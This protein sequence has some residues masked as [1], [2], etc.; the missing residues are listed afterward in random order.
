MDN[1]DFVLLENDIDSDQFR[2]QVLNGFNDYITQRAQHD[3][4]TDDD[5]DPY[6]PGH[7]PARG[8]RKHLAGVVD[9]GRYT[10]QHPYPLWPPFVKARSPC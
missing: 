8:H 10:K 3:V 9:M 2:G 1:H 7:P 6:I 5:P 4:L